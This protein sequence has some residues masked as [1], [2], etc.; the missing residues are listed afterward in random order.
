MGELNKTQKAVKDKAEAYK[1]GFDFLNNIKLPS[2]IEPD[3]LKLIKVKGID[4]DNLELD[5]RV[6]M[7]TWENKP[8]PKESLLSINGTQLLTYQNI[9]VF[10]ILHFRVY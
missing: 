4:K 9:G 2:G 3:N 5:N 10:I 8:I 7:P 6:F 1:S